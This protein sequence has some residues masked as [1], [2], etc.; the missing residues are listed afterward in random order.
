NGAKIKLPENKKV[1]LTKDS[2]GIADSFIVEFE[3]QGIQA[4]LIDISHG[5]IPELPD[6]AGIV[7]IPDSFKQDEP[8]ACQQFLKS[9]FLLAKKNAPYLMESARKKGAFLSTVTFLGGDF[10]FTQGTFASNPVYGGLAGLAKTAALEWKE[11][12]C[13]A[14][15][16]PDNVDKCIHNA[17]AAVSLIMTQGSVEMG[18]DGESCNIPNLVDKPVQ[19]KPLEL[20]HDDVVV[21]TGGAKGVTAECAVKIAQEYSPVI[22][23]LGKSEPPSPEADWIKD[24]TDMGQMKKQIITHAFTDKKPSP[25]QVE[26]V[27]RKIVSN[28]EIAKNIERIKTA[29]SKVVYISCDIR[30]KEAVKNALD[31]IRSEGKNITCIIHGAGVLEDKLIV[32]KSPEQFEKVFDTKIKG[33]D[34]LLS[35][36]KKDPLK[37]IVLFSS[38]AARA[39]NTGQSDYAMANEAL[40]KTAQKL[41]GKLSDCK[42]LSVNWGPWEGGMVNPSLKKEFTKK[43]IDLIPLDAGAKQLLIEMGNPNANAEV[44]VG[45]HLTQKKEKDKPKLSLAFEQAFNTNTCPVLNAHII[46]GKP[47]VPFALQME[48]QALAVEKNNPGLVFA[49]MDE[50]RLLKGIKAQDKKNLCQVNIGKCKPFENAFQV[51]SN[52]TSSENAG[53]NMHTHSST[54]NLLR[55]KLPEPP[56]L[57]KAA[58]MDLKPYAYSVKKAYDKILFHGSALQGIQKIN[59]YSEKGIEVVSSRAQDTAKWFENPKSRQ[60]VIDPM[61]LDAAFQAAIL[62]TFK[63]KGEVCLPSFI[64]NFRLYSSFPS[65]KGDIRILFTVNEETEHKIKGYFTFL[66]EADTVIASVTGFEAICDPSLH[67][68]FKTKPLYS[69]EQILA[70]AEGNPSEAFGNQYR[71]F[72]NDREIA[73]L[74]RPPYFFMNRVLN[75]D[76]PQWEM[77]PGGWIETE[78]E[79]PENEWYFKANRSKAMPFCILLEI[80]LQPCGWLAAYAGSALHSEQRLHFRNLGGNATYLQP[81]SCESGTLTV[82]SRL[83]EVSKAGGMIIQD[84]DMEVLQ[85]NKIA[86]KGETNFGFFT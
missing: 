71:V 59:G 31:S 24:I 54:N 56:V 83:K 50:M 76:H 38:V 62:W 46:G 34:A 15:D 74:P 8:Q 10:G 61:M 55:D 13:R 47:V 5:E 52:I 58:F 2:S 1:Y 60:W 44:V 29:G 28:R 51:P 32:D 33:L 30:I 82:R 14:L 42:V 49:G 73:R 43:G 72:D 25:A 65:S 77:K 80:A 45:G 68:K 23:L 69:R 11:V 36:T 53:E 81:I 70:F 26:K 41:S 12:L 40:N 17:E 79:V 57:S 27:Y 20:S 9:A 3:I 64:A 6:A 18:L 22:L 75:A 67:D 86:Y 37:H 7:V 66:N 19:K 4:E 84:F 16:L 35:A 39:G 78:Y 48:V 85:G 63:R 21:I